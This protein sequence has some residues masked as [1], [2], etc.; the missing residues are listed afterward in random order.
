MY[1]LLTIPHEQVSRFDT[2]RPCK[3]R[4]EENEWNWNA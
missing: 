3:K 2:D 4:N 1:L